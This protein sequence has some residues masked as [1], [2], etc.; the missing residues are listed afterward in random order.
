[1]SAASTAYITCGTGGGTRTWHFTG[2]T[3]I[4]HTLALNLGSTAAQGGNI[5]NGARNQPDR[6]TLTVIETDVGHPAGRADRMLQAMESLKRTRTLCSVVTSAR[7][8]TNML[9]SEFTATVDETSQSGWQ[10]TLAFTRYSPSP[11]AAKTSDNASRATHT[12]S[13]GPVQTVSGG[14]LAQLCDL[15][16]RSAEAETYLVQ[17]DHLMFYH[18]LCLRVEEAFFQV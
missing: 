5:V 6:V 3:S 4:E 14:Q 11:S 17:E 7:T 10:G 1:M 9:L 8:Y 15:T 18:R 12:G 13:A 2:V 16:L